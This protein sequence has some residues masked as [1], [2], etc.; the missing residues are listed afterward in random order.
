[1]TDPTDRLAEARQSFSGRTL[2][3]AQFSEAWALTG[4]LERGIRRAGTFREKLTDY[5]HAF[6]RSEKFDAIQ[7]EGALRDLF[8]TRYGQSMNQMREGLVSREADLKEQIAP[9][10]LIQ[11]RG[12]EP[13]I[14]AGETMPFY[15]AYDCQAG[16]LAQRHQITEVGAKNMMKAAYQNA[17]GRDLYA[18]GKAAEE[19]YHLPKREAAR[20]ARQAAR[21]QGQDPG[22]GQDGEKSRDP[23][24]AQANPRHYARSR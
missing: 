23:G 19:T 13:L 4:I 18:D 8:K 12:V 14:R 24:Q 16:D 10:A 3:D 7:A 17:E 22:Q 20:E 2:T 1:M 6:A 21:D 5:A 9:E 15:Q 11:A